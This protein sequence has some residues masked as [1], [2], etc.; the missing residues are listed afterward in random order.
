MTVAEVRARYERIAGQW[1]LSLAREG[2]GKMV[3]QRREMLGAVDKGVCLGLGSPSGET[4]AVHALWQLAAFVDMK[5]MFG[6]P[7]S[8]FVKMTT[9]EC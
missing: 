5:G 7:R 2:L 1:R 8:L 9:G 3:E 6:T 4:G